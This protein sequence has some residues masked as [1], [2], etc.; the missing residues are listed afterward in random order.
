MW[1]LPSVNTTDSSININTALLVLSHKFI[2]R[3]SQ[4]IMSGIWNDMAE[5]YLISVNNLSACVNTQ[6]MSALIKG[7]DIPEYF[8]ALFFSFKMF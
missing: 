1:F 6:N 7:I 4:R 8:Q 5:F 2:T 3:I